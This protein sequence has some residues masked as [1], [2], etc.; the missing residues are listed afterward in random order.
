MIFQIKEGDL[1]IQSSRII[2]FFMEKKIHEN[3]LIFHRAVSIISTDHDKFDLSESDVFEN[4]N[5]ESDDNYSVCT[6]DSS[7]NRDSDT[8]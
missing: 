5:D 1:L 6:D 4:P 3:S 7:P 8:E 2:G